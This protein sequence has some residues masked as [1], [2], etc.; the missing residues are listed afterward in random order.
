[1]RRM[2][3]VHVLDLTHHGGHHHVVL[4]VTGVAAEATTAGVSGDFS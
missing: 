2:C 1:M 4:G 3:P